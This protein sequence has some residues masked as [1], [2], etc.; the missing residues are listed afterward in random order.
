[1]LLS[2]SQVCRQYILPADCK[3]YFEKYMSY[4]SKDAYNQKNNE[5][6]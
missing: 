4:L 6:N 2:Y 3:L 5:N 1:M